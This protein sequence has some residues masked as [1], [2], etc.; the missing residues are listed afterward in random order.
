MVIH[1][2]CPPVGPTGN[3]ALDQSG[4]RVVW[5]PCCSPRLTDASLAPGHVMKSIVG[6]LSSALLAATFSLPAAAA[7]DT[8][9]GITC[10]D[11]TASPQA[12][13]GACS[14]H[15]GVKQNGVSADVPTPAAS[16][17]HTA[18]ATRP[19]TEAPTGAKGKDV[20]A[21][22]AGEATAKCKDGTLSHAK[23]HSGACSKH[24]GVTQ[25]LDK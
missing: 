4:H 16:P 25:W 1:Q 3:N 15:G 14:H 9:I 20:G 13:K 19:A 18:Q 12:G 22:M 24:G 6:L 17:T 23:T 8:A 11:G 7:G 21:A 2:P 5:N 10:A